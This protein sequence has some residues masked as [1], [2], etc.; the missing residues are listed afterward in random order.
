MS[1]SKQ[2]GFKKYD[3]DMKTNIF[4]NMKKMYATSS[5]SKVK[6]SNDQ[7][8]SRMFNDDNNCARSSPGT[9]SNVSDVT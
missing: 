1:N 9:V 3:D 2:P 8:F 4:D 7:M 5:K 6:F